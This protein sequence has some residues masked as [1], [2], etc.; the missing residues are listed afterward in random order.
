MDAKYIS[1]AGR[2][3]SKDQVQTDIAKLVRGGPM[4]QVRARIDEI[5]L[6]PD[7]MRYVYIVTSSLS[8]E[9]VKLVFDHLAANPA[10]RPDYYFVQ[11]YWLL[12]AYFSS[13]ADMGAVGFVICQP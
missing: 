9:Q 8:K 13:C 3:R 4:D 2:Y 5:R 11:L 6:A 1:W 7:A 10:S 12:T